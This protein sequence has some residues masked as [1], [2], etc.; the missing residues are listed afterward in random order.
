MGG[1]NVVFPVSTP[2]IADTANPWYA[3]EASLWN[4]NRTPVWDPDGTITSLGSENPHKT[5]PNCTPVV[6]YLLKINKIN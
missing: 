5:L 6:K 1:S 4:N 2:K 3:T